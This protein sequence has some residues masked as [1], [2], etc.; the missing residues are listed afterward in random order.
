[1]RVD[2]YGLAMGPD[3]PRPDPP[4]QPPVV[5]GPEHRDEGG[6]LLV[7]LRRGV[8]GAR[9]WVYERPGGSQAWRVGVALVGLVVIILG[10]VFL[11]VP[12]PGWLVIFAGLGIWATEFAWAGSLLGFVRRTVDAWTAWLKRQPRWLALL[13]GAV[14]LIVVAVLALWVLAQ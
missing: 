14:G 11:V 13:V 2:P 3:P 6:G 9:S 8:K 10:I 7:R 5:P 1:M 4:A 12:G